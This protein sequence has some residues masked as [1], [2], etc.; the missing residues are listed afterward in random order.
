MDRHLFNVAPR[1]PVNFENSRDQ[2]NLI[3]VSMMWNRFLLFCDRRTDFQF[4]L[5]SYFR[6][7]QTNN[8]SEKK[9]RRRER[10]RERKRERVRRAIVMGFL[11]CAGYTLIG[12][13]PPA[14]VFIEFVISR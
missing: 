3:S 12:A 1:R 11:A 10:K 7:K 6:Q 2:S 5:R 14:A 4:D 13:G 8:K 9:K